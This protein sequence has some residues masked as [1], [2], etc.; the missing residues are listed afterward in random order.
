MI[1]DT[2]QYCCK[3][4]GDA[5]ASRCTESATVA[6]AHKEEQ[7]TDAESR[8]PQQLDQLK[9]NYNN[10]ILMLRHVFLLL[11]FKDSSN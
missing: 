7:N 1:G 11:S 10:I 2:G 8:S 9:G 3:V 4:S 6:L 5:G